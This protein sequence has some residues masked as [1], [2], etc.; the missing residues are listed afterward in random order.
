[1]FNPR[2]TKVLSALA[3]VFG[4]TRRRGLDHESPPVTYGPPS[5]NGGKTFA[6]RGRRH[7]SQRSRSRRKRAALKAKR[8]RA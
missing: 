7:A 2:L 4:P 8:S 3:S 6:T 5:R 1:M